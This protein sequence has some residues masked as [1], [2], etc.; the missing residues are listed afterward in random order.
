M[1]SKN[2]LFQNIF[3]FGILSAN[4]YNLKLQRKRLS[5]MS[6]E[7]KVEDPEYIIEER[8]EWWWIQQTSLH[9]F[10]QVAP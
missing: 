10:V 2:N 3:I 9:L 1:I 8:R 5:Y 7:W 6:T 4:A